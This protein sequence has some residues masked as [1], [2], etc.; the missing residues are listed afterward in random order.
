[1]AMENAEPVLLK[2][3][4]DRCASMPYNALVLYLNEHEHVVFN[5]RIS[6]V[7]PLLSQYAVTAASEELAFRLSRFDIPKGTPGLPS[8]REYTEYDLNDRQKR[9][10]KKLQIC[11]NWT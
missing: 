1:M 11:M 3:A 7:T 2:N 5:A 10:L 6:G 4:R 9:E 8:P